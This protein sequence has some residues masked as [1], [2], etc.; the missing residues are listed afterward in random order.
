MEQPDNENHI[1][2]GWKDAELSKSGVEKAIKLRDQIKGKRFDV[3][4]CSDL[5]RAID[6]AKLTWGKFGFVLE[7]SERMEPIPAKGK[8]GFWGI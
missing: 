3:V 8:L 6:S 4:F 5:R 7:N 1:A 2:S